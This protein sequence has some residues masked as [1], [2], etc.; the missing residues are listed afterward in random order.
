MRA[1][2]KFL[3]KENM[4]YK[5][6]AKK[7]DVSESLI[8]LYMKNRRSPRVKTAIKL[9]N[10]TGIPREFF[11]FDDADISKRGDTGREELKKYLNENNLTYEAFAKKINRS[12]STVAL[13]LSQR[14]TPRV[15]VV[16]DIEKI[17][18][19]PKERIYFAKK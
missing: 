15:D 14:R 11:V 9:E 18:G 4:T 13:F 6:L 2:E 8:C 3:K 1:L 16:R 7:I 5:E 10:I 19:I 12:T 17:T